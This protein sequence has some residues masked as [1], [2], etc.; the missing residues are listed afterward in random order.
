MEVYIFWYWIVLDF[1]KCVFICFDVN[2]GDVIGEFGVEEFF[3]L[4][5]L[6]GFSRCLLVM[7]V[8]TFTIVYGLYNGCFRFIIW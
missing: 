3:I 1:W 5:L 8:D 2:V 7:V 4:E 6:I